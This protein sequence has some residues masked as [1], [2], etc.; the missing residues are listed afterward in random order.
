M[1]G[2]CGWEKRLSARLEDAD[3]PEQTTT[4]RFVADIYPEST[5]IGSQD[6]SS[7]GVMQVNSDNQ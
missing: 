5:N 6:E 4:M 3:N 7:P 1:G 2:A